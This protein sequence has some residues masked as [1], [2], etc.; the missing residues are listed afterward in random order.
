MKAG[1][2]LC[3]EWNKIEGVHTPTKHRNEDEAAHTLYVL[4]NVLDFTSK[5][6]INIFEEWRDNPPSKEI[7]EDFRKVVNTA[8]YG[9]YDSRNSTVS[10]FLINWFSYR[11][12]LTMITWFIYYGLDLKAIYLKSYYDIENNLIK[13]GTTVLQDLEEDISIKEEL[14]VILKEIKPLIFRDSLKIE[15]K[16]ERGKKYVAIL[17]LIHQYKLK[18]YIKIDSY[19]SKWEKDLTPEKIAS[20]IGETAFHNIIN[21]VFNCPLS[22]I[23]MMED[24]EKETPGEELLEDFRDLLNYFSECTTLPYICDVVSYVHS[25]E[26]IL[27]FFTLARKFGLDTEKIYDFKEKKGNLIEIIEYRLHHVVC[28]R[29]DL[30]RVKAGQIIARAVKSAMNDE[31]V[32]TKLRYNIEKRRFEKMLEEKE[33]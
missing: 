28:L 26:L 16:E 17:W 21:K 7:L 8:S 19:Y 25:K 24:W 29:D 2:L 33:K 11:F 4:D 27:K 1:T 12:R 5:E 6:L 32:M 23:K 30:L 31:F 14:L 13:T 22:L 18:Y 20:D 15:E 10:R 9:F 3:R